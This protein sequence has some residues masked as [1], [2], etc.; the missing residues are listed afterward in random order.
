MY[1]TLCLCIVCYVCVLCV[2]FCTLYIVFVF[3][4]CLC[5]VHCVCVLYVVFVYCVLCLCIVCVLYV[6]FVYCM[7]CL[8]ITHCVHCIPQICG[9]VCPC[10]GLYKYSTTAQP[11]HECCSSLTGYHIGKLLNTIVLNL[12]E[13]IPEL[14]IPHVT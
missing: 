5:I 13:T 6:L 14:I 2:V 3:M 7:S 10:S 9:Y 12:L 8:C 11:S 4:Y 1:Y